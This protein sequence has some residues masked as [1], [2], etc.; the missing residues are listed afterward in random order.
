M[1]ASFLFVAWEKTLYMYK[2]CTVTQLSAVVEKIH[3]KNSKIIFVGQFDLPQ[4]YF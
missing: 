4:L 3:V 1:F 2:C